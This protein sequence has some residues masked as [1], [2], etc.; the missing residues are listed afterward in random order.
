ML[1]P[2]SR[3]LVLL[4]SHLGLSPDDELAP[5]TLRD[6]NSLARKMKSSGIA[7]PGGL[8]GLSVV[9]IQKQLGLTEQDAVRLGRLLSREDGLDSEIRRL[10][11][12]GISIMTRADEAYPRNY[13]ERLHESA[14]IILFYAGE[15]ALLGQPGIAVVGSRHL[16][17]AGQECARFIG[18]TC[19]Y[20][21]LVLY[22][23]GAKGV[24]SL[25]MHAALEGRGSAVAILAESLEKA[26]RTTE[27]KSALKRGDLCLATP[28]LPSA[29]FS[30]GAAMGRN[31]LIYCLA[32]YAIV[33]ASDFENGGTWAGATEALKFGWLP[34]FVLDHP[35]MPEGNRRLMQ[36]GGIAFPYP[37]PEHHSKLPDWLKEHSRPAPPKVTQLG[38]F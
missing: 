2:D 32:D 25:S 17:Q 11:S 20:S 27:N 33:V 22:S 3:V 10:E 19:G 31:R 28:Y 30:V 12:H 36:K 21:G 4:C 24:D 16:D 1:S 14:P 23:G 29:G 7:T 18:N 35:A 13:I 9:D 26:M 8:L 6:W 15:P 37:F 38:M 5:L 34:V